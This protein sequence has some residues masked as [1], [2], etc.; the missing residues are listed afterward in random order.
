MKKEAFME[1]ILRFPQTLEKL[2]E[3]MKEY[4]DR[5]KILQKVF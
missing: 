4:K 2:K 1:M 3:R 5:Q